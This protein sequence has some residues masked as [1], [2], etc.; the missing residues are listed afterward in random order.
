[1]SGEARLK[2]MAAT[3]QRTEVTP[4]AAHPRVRQP[5]AG[6]GPSERAGV[7]RTMKE[8]PRRRTARPRRMRRVSGSPRRGQARRAV[9]KGERRRVPERHIDQEREGGPGEGGDGGEEEAEGVLTQVQGRAP[10]GRGPLL[11]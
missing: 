10:G 9:T 8:M 6:G 3:P 11:A 4:A 7:E 1:M 2:K 5:G